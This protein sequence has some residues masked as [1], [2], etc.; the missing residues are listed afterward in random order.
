VANLDAHSRKLEEQL[1]GAEFE[2]ESLDRSNRADRRRLRNFQREREEIYRRFGEVGIPTAV[3]DM[4]AELAQR[5]QGLN[6]DPETGVAKLD[7]DI[8]FDTAQA[9][10]RPEASKLLT[11]FAVI[12]RTPEARDLR[13][14]AVGHTDDRKVEGADVRDVYPN[15]WHLGA[16][17]ALAVTDFLRVRGVNESRMGMA[18]YGRYQPIVSNSSD[19]NRQRNRRVE[20]FLIA[21]DVPVVGWTETLPSVYR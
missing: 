11:E 12:L 10:L 6:Y 18:S 16:A 2:L 7:A 3:N 4:L 14:M 15:N 8:L 5:Y 9:E 1:G 19:P 13:I 20:L 17:R 21:S